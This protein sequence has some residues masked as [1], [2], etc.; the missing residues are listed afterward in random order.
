VADWA[1]EV[2]IQNAWVMEAF[3]RIERAGLAEVRYLEG[4]HDAYLRKPEVTSQLRLP[5]RE[6]SYR[7]LSD[8]LFVEHGHRFD[9]WN[10]DEVQ[11]YYEVGRTRIPS[12]SGPTITRGLLHVPGLRS[13]EGL[14]EFYSALR[15]PSNRDKYLLGATLVYLF[16]RFE[17]N[18]KPFSIYAMGHTHECMMRRFDVRAQYTGSYHDE[19]T[20][21]EA[22]P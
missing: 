19:A 15:S 7:G 1:L 3:R 9:S 10:Y 20:A 2:M 13:W 14:G 4:N 16:E 8:D 22:R 21:G 5:H 6:L 17:A 12:L 11:G 18:Q